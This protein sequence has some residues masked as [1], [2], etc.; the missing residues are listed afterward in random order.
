MS[1]DQTKKSSIPPTGIP[2][3]MLPDSKAGEGSKVKALPF[4]EYSQSDVMPA[5]EVT[6]QINIH[7]LEDL[8]NIKRESEVSAY[9]IVRRPDYTKVRVNLD[10][11]VTIIGRAV[12]CDIVVRDHKTSREHA[13]VLRLD[14]SSFELEDL[15]S[16][17]GTWSDGVQVSKMRLLNGDSFSVGG[18][19][20]TLRVEH[21]HAIAN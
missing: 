9:L 4:D 17:N 18:A 5:R 14:R 2:E 13:R 20:F 3:E 16:R 12:S 10:R 1:D 15:G 7:E 21:A 8:R 19:V 11:E 6:D